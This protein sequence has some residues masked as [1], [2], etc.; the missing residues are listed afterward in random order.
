MEK[1]FE[2]LKSTYKKDRDLLPGAVLTEWAA[3]VLNWKRVDLHWI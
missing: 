1:D 3:M 2:Y